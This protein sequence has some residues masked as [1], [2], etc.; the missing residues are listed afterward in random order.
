MAKRIARRLAEGAVVG[1]Y[2]GRS[3]WGPRALGNRSVIAHP[4]WPGIR[5]RINNLM[6][7]R[8]SFM[9]FAPAVLASRCADYFLDPVSPYMMST[10]R[11]R[12]EWVEGR[13]DAVL[14]RDGTARAQAVEPERSPLLASIIAEFEQLT[15]IPMVLNTSFN[16]HGL[17]MVERPEEAMDHLRW[18]C[19]DELAIGGRLLRR[20]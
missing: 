13:I 3:E 11:V 1:L 7:R 4:G 16:L 2:H 6:K 10:T 9:P 5:D 19:V 15:G 12:R 20:N 17:P 18:G 14:N 8:E